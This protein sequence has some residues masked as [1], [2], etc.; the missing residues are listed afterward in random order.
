MIVFYI[1]FML[2]EFA[3]N[4][5]II[6]SYLYNIPISVEIIKIITI[7]IEKKESHTSDQ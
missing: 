4:T 2:T 1:I 3:R 7:I 6:T 5:I